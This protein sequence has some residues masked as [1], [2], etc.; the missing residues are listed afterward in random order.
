MTNVISR[1]ERFD[2]KTHILDRNETLG[3]EKK[4]EENRL[5]GG[6]KQRDIREEYWK[7]AGQSDKLDNWEPVRVK[8]LEGE[9]DGTF[10]E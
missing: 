8:R 1:Y 6:F 4:R 9:M 7:L 3:L 5:K 10:D 2:R